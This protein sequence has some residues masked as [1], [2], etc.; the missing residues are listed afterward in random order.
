MKP[1]ILYRLLSLLSILAAFGS[2]IFVI[3]GIIGAVMDHGFRGDLF[4]SAFGFLTM[5]VGLHALWD[6]G[7]RLVRVEQAQRELLRSP[8]A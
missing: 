4:G 6:I 8:E 3:L 5:A 1:R 2:V 7:T